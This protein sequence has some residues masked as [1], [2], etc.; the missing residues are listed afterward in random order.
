MSPTGLSRLPLSAVVDVFQATYAFESE[1]NGV[2]WNDVLRVLTPADRPAQT[3]TIAVAKRPLTPALHVEA[4]VAEVAGLEASGALSARQANRLKRA[5]ESAVAWI[6]SGRTALGAIQLRVFVFEV[7][8][9]MR[10]RSATLT[11][12]QGTSLVNAALAVIARLRG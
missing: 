9:L 5:L 11:S 10:P 4:I 1:F 8:A 3:L 12:S 6:N 7:R 2:I